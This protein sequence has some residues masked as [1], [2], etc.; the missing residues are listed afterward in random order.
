MISLLSIYSI[1]N[2]E[3]LFCYCVDKSI[4]SARTVYYIVIIIIDDLFIYYKDIRCYELWTIETGEGFFS[5]ID[6]IYQSS[7]SSAISKRIEKNIRVD[8]NNATVTR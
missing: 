3:R 5:K 4:N 6:I 1:G 7:F 2:K 8:Y